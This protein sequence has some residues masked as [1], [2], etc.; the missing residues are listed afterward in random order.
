MD[1]ITDGFC[2]IF[3]FRSDQ[4]LLDLAL[5]PPPP[6]A[7]ENLSMAKSE[8]EAATA[9]RQIRTTGA[10][11]NSRQRQQVRLKEKDSRGCKVEI[12]E[13]EMQ[14]DCEPVTS[15]ILGSV[16]ISLES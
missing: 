12:S 1:I 10:G 4:D 6:F 9:R 14:G 3:M 7:L 5:L 13:V 11:Y 16:A 2:Y 8:A 15:I